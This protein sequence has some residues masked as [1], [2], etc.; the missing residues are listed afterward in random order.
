MNN[1]FRRY[2]HDNGSGINYA[3]LTNGTTDWYEYQSTLSS[4][5]YKLMVDINDF[6]ISAT[7]DASALFP[8]NCKIVEIEE[9]PID[10]FDKPGRWKYKENKIIYLDDNYFDEQLAKT[11]EGRT[12]LKNRFLGEAGKIIAPLQDAV[13]LEMATEKEMQILKRWKKY[14]VLINRI[15]PL[16][17]RYDEWPQKPD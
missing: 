17:D 9:I 14:R 12:L 15:N 4:D 3:S 2:Q 13:E 7:K 6:V 5:K 16:D 11:S 8:E 1:F 10:F